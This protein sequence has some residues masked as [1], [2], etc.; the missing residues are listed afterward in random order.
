MTDKKGWVLVDI[1]AGTC[2]Y[3]EKF[4]DCFPNLTNPLDVKV[5]DKYNCNPSKQ[6]NEK[7]QNVINALMK[8]WAEEPDEKRRKQIADIQHLL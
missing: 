6:N 7:R 5:G 1:S 4:S 3:F 8:L 2:V